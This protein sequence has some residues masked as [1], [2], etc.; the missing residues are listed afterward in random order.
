MFIVP[1][2]NIENQPLMPTNILR[3]RRWITSKKATPFWKKGIF[4]VRLNIRTKENKQE[5]AIGIDPGS[6]KEAFTVKSKSHTYLNIQADAVTWVKG[7][8]EERRNARGAR[9]QRNTPCRKPRFNKAKGGL[10]PSTKARWQWKLRIINWLQ[11]LFPVSMI[12]VE[13]IKAR[14]MG[15]RKWDKSF[16]PLQVGKKWFYSQ[17]PN[18]E[19]K[20]GWETKILRDNV[21]L[22]KSGN[23]LSNNFSAHC[24]DSWVLANW[25]VGGHD[26]PEN[27]KM[28]LVVP[29][30]FHR[31]QLH[32]F[33]PSK[34]GARKL[35][36][37]TRSLGLKR[38]SLVKHFK[39]GLVYIG[40]SSKGKVSLHSVKTGVR[41][42]QKANAMN[43][44]FK[45]FLSW[46]TYFKEAVI[47]PTT[48]KGRGF[49]TE[50]V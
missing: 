30:Q 49:L 29:M 4:C 31:R 1:V 12:V 39:Y 7:T 41:L 50:I 35:Y 3:A 19:L 20:Q 27:K 6:K 32:V 37:G 11:K 2:T 9:R 10:S 22:K 15:K 42:T 45:T 40:G 48:L 5:I 38:G 16:S 17:L 21:G 8:I 24:V 13:D 34:N 36:G 44:K 26:L 14:T 46:R 33:Q 23:K 43:C 18:L 47:P 25:F 28:L